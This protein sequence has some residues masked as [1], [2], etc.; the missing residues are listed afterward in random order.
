VKE[1]KYIIE[2]I[3]KNIWYHTTTITT[4]NNSKLII[5]FLLYIGYDVNYKLISEYKYTV[6]EE[7]TKN[8]VETFK[9]EEEEKKEI[10]AIN[11][12]TIRAFVFSKSTRIYVYKIKRKWN[13][14][15]QSS[16]S[17]PVVSSTFLCVNICSH[18]CDIFNFFVGRINGAWAF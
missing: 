9:L 7:R 18:L 3:K 11:G 6:K 2:V 5:I 16:L 13:K 15:V 12:M 8:W 4:T 14:S 1:K 10:K 17:S